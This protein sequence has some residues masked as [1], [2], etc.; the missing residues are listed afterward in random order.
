M[1]ANESAEINAAAAAATAAIAANAAAREAANAV[2]AAV[3]FAAANAAG[4]GLMLHT[5][6]AANAAA[7][8]ATKKALANAP[9]MPEEA[10]ATALP[11]LEPPLGAPGAYAAPR[12]VLAPSSTEMNAAT[13]KVVLDATTIKA[14]ITKI[15]KGVNPIFARLSAL[16][17]EMHTLLT[18]ANHIEINMKRTR[19][20]IVESG[21]KTH[22]I[23]AS[24]I[25]DIRADES[26]F[27]GIIKTIRAIREQTEQLFLNI[28]SAV[29][30]ITEIT[31][32]ILLSPEAYS[33]ASVAEKAASDMARNA[34]SSITKQAVESAEFEDRIN[35]NLEQSE[36][37][38]ESVLQY[39]QDVN[40]VIEEKAGTTTTY[41]NYN[42]LEEMLR[43]T[44]SSVNYGSNYGSNYNL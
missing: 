11:T 43:A 18:K 36:D 25:R 3:A 17:R 20:K 38:Y 41:E 9:P 21:A 8:A 28:K 6:A 5:N 32:S 44:E 37:I 15:I 33:G 7:N 22:K 29:Q 31:S 26:S 23:N 39:V 12:R 2:N 24:F 30:S 42:I 10:L 16:T 19:N 27:L 14:D 35:K 4:T 1:T 13:A 40:H 34:V